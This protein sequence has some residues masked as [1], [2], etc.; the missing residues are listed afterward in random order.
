MEGDQ[1]S[2][3][4]GII[5]AFPLTELRNAGV[6]P[7]FSTPFISRDMNDSRLILEWPSTIRAG[8]TNLIDLTF[9]IGGNDAI[10]LTRE[11][12]DQTVESGPEE[13][14]EANGK[15]NI[16][17]AARLEMH[18]VQFSPP[19]MIY[20]PLHEMQQ[21]TIHWNLRPQ[22]DGDYRGLVWF[23]LQFVSQEDGAITERTISAQPI[24]I[25][26]ISLWGLKTGTVRA[27]GLVGIFLGA[28]LIWP[29]LETFLRSRLN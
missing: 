15:Y 8:D 16:V 9:E 20:Q 22:E 29:F 25:H 13:D 4:R 3:Y 26:V 17:A 24:E 23:Y 12:N 11:L 1:L 6:M 2:V 10:N 28:I 21:I 7:F 14:L 19:E 18:G 5:T 27:G